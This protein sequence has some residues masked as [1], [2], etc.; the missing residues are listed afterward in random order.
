M[1]RAPPRAKRLVVEEVP[2]TTFKARCLALV[3]DVRR[4]RRELVI[5]KHG[6]PVARVVSAEAPPAWPLLRDDWQGKIRVVGDIVH[7]DW[8]EEFDATRTVE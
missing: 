8:S 6:K 2:I 5:T 4:H 1:K 7:C 3:E